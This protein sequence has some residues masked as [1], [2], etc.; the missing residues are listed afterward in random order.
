MPSKSDRLPT[1]KYTQHTEGDS[2]KIRSRSTE[3]PPPAI[4]T[5]PQQQI[6][7]KQH[8]FEDSMDSTSSLEEGYWIKQ[9]VLKKYYVCAIYIKGRG[10]WDAPGLL[11]PAQF[12]NLSLY[13]IKYTN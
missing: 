9:R 7:S 4:V 8:V 10:L 13:L 5:P 11:I 2:I 12:S 6:T 1:L 3:L